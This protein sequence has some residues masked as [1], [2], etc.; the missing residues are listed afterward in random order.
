MSKFV[1]CNSYG[2]MSNVTNDIIPFLSFKG[3]YILG[4]NVIGISGYNSFPDKG[5]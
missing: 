1:E 2:I 5:N 4:Y 3:N